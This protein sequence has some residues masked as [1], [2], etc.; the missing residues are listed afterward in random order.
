MCNCTHARGYPELQELIAMHSSA[1]QHGGDLNTDTITIIDATLDLR[2][3][4]VR[5]ASFPLVNCPSA[6]RASHDADR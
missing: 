4:V 3:K 6:A 5:Q 2:E 1:G